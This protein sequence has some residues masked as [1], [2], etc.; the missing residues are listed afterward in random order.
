VERANPL[1]G[2]RLG[3]RPLTHVSGG[4][5]AAVFT[6]TSAILG[7]EITVERGLR[8]GGSPWLIR[9]GGAAVVLRVAPVDSRERLATE[10]AM[11]IELNHTNV[12]ARDPRASAQFPA[13]IL[14]LEVD[15]P[16]SH[17]IP[18]R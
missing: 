2:G 1:P 6:W 17:F 16:A 4:P 15:P 8:Q 11:A 12:P 14:G 3:A 10:V 13:G 5:E 9:A 18:S 7:G